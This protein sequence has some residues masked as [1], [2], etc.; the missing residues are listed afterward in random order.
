MQ[1]YFLGER[2]CCRLSPFFVNSVKKY[3]VVLARIAAVKMILKISKQK[4]TKF[5]TIVCC[6]GICS[7]ARNVGCGGRMCKIP[8]KVNIPT[9]M[10]QNGH[11][12]AEQPPHIPET[13]CNQHQFNHQQLTNQVW[14]P[15]L[16][17][18][19]AWFLPLMFLVLATLS[20]E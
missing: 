14:T 15:K 18:N 13:F 20:G 16:L 19:M 8:T 17:S 5:W 12:A 6:F 9:R 3:P 4:S 2:I 1:I 7:E 11:R 10:V